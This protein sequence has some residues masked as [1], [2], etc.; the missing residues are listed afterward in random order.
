MLERKYEGVEQ[1]TALSDALYISVSLYIYKKRLGLTTL[2]VF[3]YMYNASLFSTGLT[4]NATFLSFSY[5]PG[6]WR[7]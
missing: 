7:C 4:T 6:L 2:Y 1:R 5:S 3:T